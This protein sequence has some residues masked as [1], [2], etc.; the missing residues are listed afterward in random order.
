[1]AKP[2]SIYQPNEDLLKRLGAFL[3]S[4]RKKHGLTQQQLGDMC[5]FHGKFIQ[6]LETRPRNISIS[7]FVQ[8]AE[9]LNIEADALLRAVL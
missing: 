5:D 3:R 6:T 9:G 4:Y 8:L 2:D 7:A 1:M